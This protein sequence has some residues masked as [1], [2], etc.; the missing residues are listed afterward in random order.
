MARAVPVRR[1]TAGDAEALAV[2]A[3]QTFRDTFA[4]DNR[5]ADMEAYVGRA[6][7]PARVAAELADGASTFL[8][9]GSGGALAGYAKLRS[10]TSGPGVVGPHPVELERLYVDRAAL[11]QGVGAALM[12]ACLDAAAAAGYRTLWLGVWERNARALAFYERW[13][14][15]AVGEHT[16]QLGADAQRDLV[17][18]RPVAG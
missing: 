12:Q 5:P 8:V 13:G 1:A 10:G 17:L 2:L 3:T 6:F 18:A 16:F 15:A 4:E 9:A 11:G 14:F 7:A